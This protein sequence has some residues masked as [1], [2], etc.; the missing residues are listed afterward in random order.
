MVLNTVQKKYKISSAGLSDIGKVRQNN[1]DVFALLPEE[2]CYIIADGM[3]G[4]QAGEIAAKE[5]VKILSQMLV[6]AQQ[7][8]VLV[9]K[10][11][12]EIRDWFREAIAEINRRIFVMGS[13]SE[14][15]YGMGT[16]V[17][18]LYFCGE[19]AIYSHVGDSRIYRLRNNQLKQLT[20]DHSLLRE[21]IDLGQI[22]EEQTEYLMYKN[23]LT[24]A[25][26][27]E[28][29]VRP[30]VHASEVQENDLY[31]MCTDGLTDLLSK[32]DIQRVLIQNISSLELCAK[33]LVEQAKAQ[34]GHDNITVVLAHLH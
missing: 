26:G 16:T 10:T 29:Q 17:C 11:L 22:D 27:T 5:T 9:G 14:G 33:S 23:I 3:G 1:E 20:K 18:C 25:I 12:K 34:G 4:H 32:E 24:K 13:T 8:H 2:N 31:L 28:P 7:N 6:L 15:L 19:N 21:L 30:S